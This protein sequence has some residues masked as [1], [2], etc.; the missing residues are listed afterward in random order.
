MNVIAVLID[1]ELPKTCLHCHFLDM[2]YGDECP[3]SKKE[4]PDIHIRPDWCPLL[5]VADWHGDKLDNFDEQ[6]KRA[7]K[8]V[9]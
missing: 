6:N 7:M 1:S 3:I 5:I 4:I 9:M 2:V 8:E